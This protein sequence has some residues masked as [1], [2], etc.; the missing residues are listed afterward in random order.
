MSQLRPNAAASETTGMVWN[1][2]SKGGIQDRA[3]VPGWFGDGGMLDI[4]T[5]LFAKI[6]C[7]TPSQINPSCLRS[8]ISTQTD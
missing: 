6:M 1:G 7:C 2:L 4:Q 5:L 8:L 3:L